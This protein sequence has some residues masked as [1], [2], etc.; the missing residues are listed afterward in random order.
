MYYI[1]KTLKIEPKS[2]SISNPYLYRLYSAILRYYNY[3][4]IQ[5]NYHNIMVVF[6]KN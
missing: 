6:I 5:I 4:S 2:S 1:R 3:K